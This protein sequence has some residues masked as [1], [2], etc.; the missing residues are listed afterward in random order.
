MSNAIITFHFYIVNS[1][2]YKNLRAYTRGALM[3][4]TTRSNFIWM[5]ALLAAQRK[6]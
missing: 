3:R 6:P 2:R 5:L 1:P 4:K